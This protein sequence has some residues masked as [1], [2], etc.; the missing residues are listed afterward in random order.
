MNGVHDRVRKSDHQEKMAIML[1]GAAHKIS[2]SVENSA[3]H[4]GSPLKTIPEMT[5]AAVIPVRTADVLSRCFV[6]LLFFHT[7]G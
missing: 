4:Q 7:L 6:T 3:R 5:V 1:C 2:L